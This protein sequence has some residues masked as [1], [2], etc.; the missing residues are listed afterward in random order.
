M[1]AGT[2]HAPF[3]RVRSM[4]AGRRKSYA[5]KE[6]VFGKFFQQGELP[7]APWL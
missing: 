2:L 4:E 6:R 5:P 1:E 7:I 3:A